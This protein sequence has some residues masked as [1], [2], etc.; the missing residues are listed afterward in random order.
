MIPFPF[1][2]LLLV[3]LSLAVVA[4]LA[5][6]L[7]VCPVKESLLTAD[8]PRCDVVHAGG[9]LDDSLRLAASA[10]RMLHTEGSGQSRPSGGVVGVSR[11]FTDV[12]GLLLHDVPPKAP[13]HRV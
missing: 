9:G 4:V 3:P 11:P 7:Q 6:W 10:Q 13:L 2:Y 12:A 1:L 8:G 5:Q